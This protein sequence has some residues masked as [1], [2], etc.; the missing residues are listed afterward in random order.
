MLVVTITTFKSGQAFKLELF[1]V[2]ITVLDFLSL[3][4]DNNSGK[5]STVGINQSS[6][7]SMVTVL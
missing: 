2:T 6:S 1:P 5:S 4:D 3:G 7:S